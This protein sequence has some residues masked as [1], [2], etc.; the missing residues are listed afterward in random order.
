MWW[1]SIVIGSVSEP[2]QNLWVVISIIVL[3]PAKV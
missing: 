1:E 2:H 3:A